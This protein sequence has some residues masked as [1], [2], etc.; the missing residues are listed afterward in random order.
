M[1]EIGQWVRSRDG[2]LIG[3]VVEVRLGEGGPEYLVRSPEVKVETEN[4]HLVPGDNL[5]AAVVEDSHF[6][7]AIDHLIC[8]CDE[9]HKAGRADDAEKVWSLALEFA[10]PE[11]GDD[12]CPGCGSSSHS[13]DS[14]PEFVPGV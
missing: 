14:C 3:E 7:V 13:V 2:Y 11:G 9:F 10:G 8:A 1:F 4:R 6:Q 5:E 12:I